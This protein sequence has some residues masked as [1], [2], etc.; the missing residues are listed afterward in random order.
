VENILAQQQGGLHHSITE[1]SRGSLSTGSTGLPMS[2]TR[3][4]DGRYLAIDLAAAEGARSAEPPPATG[5][6]WRTFWPG[7]R[8]ASTTASRRC[9]GA[10][11][12]PARRACPCR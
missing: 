8:A 2:L 5:A 7:N 1:V 6:R 9:L 12:Q 10:A 3:L 11:C 4:P